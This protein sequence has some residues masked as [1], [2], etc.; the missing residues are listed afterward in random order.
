MLTV[1]LLILLLNVISAQQ[2]VAI[3]NNDCCAEIVLKLN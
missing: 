1:T 3:C 2:C